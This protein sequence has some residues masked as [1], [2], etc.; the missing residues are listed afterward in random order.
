V[1][2]SDRVCARVISLLALAATT[3]KA[4]DINYER[5]RMKDILHNVSKEVA[6]SYFDPALNDLDWRSLT[7]RAE[8]TIES[9]HSIGAMV[10]AI[11]GL[12][13]SLK[14]SHTVFV[15]PPYAD[16]L[17]YGFEAKAYGDQVLIDSVTPGGPAARAGLACGDRL[18]AVNGFA[19][20]RG[21]V[22][23]TLLFFRNL[24]PVSTIELGVAAGSGTPRSVKVAA[25]VKKGVAHIDLTHM[26]S[27]FELLHERESHRIPFHW[28]HYGGGVDYLQITSFEVAPEFLDTLLKELRGGK[29]FV[30]DLRDNP[31]GLIK[32]LVS[33][34]GHFVGEAQEMGE[35][36]ERGKKEPL[37]V[38]P[39]GPSVAG[40]V[41]LLTDSRS[42]SC[43]EVFA[44]HLQRT[45]RAVV[46]G[47][48]TAGR[49]SI[50]HFFPGSVGSDRIVLYGVEVAT[51]RLLLPGGEDL[52]GHGVVPDKL[53]LPSA[54]DL[55][56]KRDPCLD[57]AL[58]EARR[59]LDAKP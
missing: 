15:P 39:R 57:Q 32:S 29:A 11:Y 35:M 44:R 30:L 33:F 10:A 43:A 25:D 58:G 37:R 34:A 49:A 36:L 9:A 42:A 48:R 1:T 12:V 50:A 59:A 40:P 5:S 51:A 19:V 28:A 22:D 4:A 6:R 31:G 46:V 16:R 18:L 54:E 41:V 13:D 23:L 55:E 2:P 53:C 52:E 21:N 47:D 7:F 14:N 3:A 20:N 56:A 26:E 38:E 8:G 17:Y 27:V 45:G 24:R